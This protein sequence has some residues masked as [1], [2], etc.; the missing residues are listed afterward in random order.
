[1]NIDRLHEAEARFLQR[2]PGGFSD[3][4]LVPINKKH[5]VDK[6]VEYSNEHLSKSRFDRPQSVVEA[7]VNAV[8][9]SS[10]VSRFEKPPFRYFVDSL[11][12][13]QRQTLAA[14][15]YQRLYGDKEAGFEELVELLSQG[16]L[17]KWSIVSVVPFYCAPTREVFVK[18][19]T[20]KNILTYLEVDGLTYDSM[21]S[22]EFY[23]GY[24]DL[25][26]QIKK[27]V[28][29]SLSPNNAAL[30]GFLMMSV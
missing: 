2:Y 3:P 25:V 29:P 7:L 30:T 19:T 23:K 20:A 11:S 17:A 18:P 15:F 26:A 22:W 4:G 9:R 6:L 27:A 8:S 12:T 10:M 13:V 1:M 14:A 24:R 21:P 5:N 16:K 28:V